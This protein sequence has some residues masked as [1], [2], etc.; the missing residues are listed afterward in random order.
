MAKLEARVADLEA[1]LA[2]SEARN[3]ALSDELGSVKVE[4]AAR[5]D[6]RVLATS[7]DL[8]SEVGMVQTALEASFDNFVQSRQGAEVETAEKLWELEKVP[9]CAGVL[10]GCG[11]TRGQRGAHPGPAWG[12]DGED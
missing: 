1:R 11:P 10:G 6:E 7:R 5:M 2:A 8:H 3:E 9:A 4:V 12:G